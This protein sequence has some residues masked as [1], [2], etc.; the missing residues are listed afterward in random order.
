MKIL[1]LGWELPPHNSGG[2]GV[3]CYELAKALAHEGAKIHLILPQVPTGIASPH[4]SVMIQGPHDSLE[5]VPN[6]YTGS[7]SHIRR[8]QLRQVDYVRAHGDSLKSDAIH[9]HD[10]LTFEAAIAAKEIT[11]APLIAHVHAT[12]FDRAGNRYG[13]PVIHEIERHGLLMADRILAVSQHTKRVIIERY[14]IPSD[15]IEVVYNGNTPAI[16]SSACATTYA[17]LRAMQNEG[18]VVVAS[19]GRLTI[20][21][22][23]T[24]LLRAGVMAN[25][26][27]DRFIF[28]IAGDGEQRDEL[29]EL[30]AELGVADR[31]IFT[32]FVRGEAW[33]SVHDVA[34][35]FVMSSVSEPFGLSALEAASYKT[36]TIVTKQSGVGE[37]MS[38]FLKYD[39]WDERR[40]AD[41][42]VNLAAS[43]SLRRE[44]GANAEREVRHLSWQQV[45]KNCLMHYERTRGSLLV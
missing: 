20:Q 39:Y 7:L 35:I 4:E 9:A 30:A 31:V 18:Y 33:R 17:Y 38:S 41:Q 21:K 32:G 25:S 3:A 45:A 29:I 24:H 6:A 23:L 1:M 14:K 5:V 19:L 11:G 12:E 36:A 37:V 13:N 26:L 2:L 8:L 16:P 42:L 22:G 43:L 15:K 44:L 40:L 10:W 34:D 28:L 27:L